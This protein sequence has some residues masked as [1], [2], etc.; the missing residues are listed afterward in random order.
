MKNHTV[1]PA[2]ERGHSITDRAML[3][4]LNISAWNATLTDKAV[5]KEVAAKHNSDVKMGK[6][7]KHLIDPAALAKVDSIGGAL[8]VAHYKWTLPWQDKGVRILSAKAYFDYSKEINKLIADYRAAAREFQL[9]YPRF[10]QEARALLNGLYDE[11]NYPSESRV[12]SY[13]DAK[14]RIGNI[15]S[16]EDFRVDLGTDET[17]RIRREMQSDLDETLKTAMRDAWQR[18]ASVVQKMSDR[19]KAYTVNDKGKVENAFRD[20]LVTNIADV[21]DILP[22]L[23]LT[24][25]TSLDSIAQEIRASLT[26]H[27]P[28]E[29]RDKQTLRAETAAR[30]DEILA[31]MQGYF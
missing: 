10:K 17:E 4:T 25:D 31:K 14:V 27:T 2:S 13:F 16:A 3:V 7:R 29:L 20:T 15:D 21:L 11:R 18:L 6:F 8:R 5:S 9:E 30:A 19:L 1:A 24:G 28:D 26:I 12:A 23:N 22:A